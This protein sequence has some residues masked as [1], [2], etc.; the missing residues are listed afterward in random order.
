MRLPARFIAGNVIWGWDGSVW[1]VY[2]VE[3]VSYPWLP[4]HEKLRMHARTKDALLALPGEAMVVSICAALPPGDLPELA[5]L[6]VDP[7]ERRSFLVAKLSAR[8]A[9]RGGHAVFGP[10]A[11]AVLGAF[12]LAS[13]PAG[14]EEVAARTDQAEH[15]LAR[16]GRL[17]P[18]RA[19]AA[20]EVCWLY[21]SAVRRGL[22]PCPAQPT[23]ADEA[24]RD[25]V[26]GPH[27]VALADAI[28]KEGGLPSDRD[29]PAHRRYLRVEAE[30]GVVYQGLLAVSDM[31]HTFRFP[32]GGGE[33]LPAAD[34]A[35]FPV[36]WCV[37]IRPVSN[38]TAQASARR[39]AR[40]LQSQ[41]GEHAGDP[42]GAP[43]GLSEA[44]ETIH[45]LRAQLAANPAD[46]ELEVSTILA[47][48][49]QDL[50]ELEERVSALRSMYAAEGYQ[51]HRPIG[52]Q[53]GLFEAL[54]PGSPF[55]RPAGDYLHHLLGRD[56]A[57]GMPFGT[58]G[59]GD[60]EGMLLGYCAD[61]GTFRPVL[62]DPARGPGI[63]RSGSLGAFGALGS[64]KS[65]FIKNVLHAT[66]ARGGRVVAL[67]RTAAGEYVRVADVVPGRAQVV[68][69][70]GGSP[71]CLD[72]MRIF[73]PEERTDVALGFLTLITGTA[74]NELP[75]LALAEAVRVVAQRPKGRLADVLEVLEQ[76]S[77]H[78]AG[79]E[80]AWRILRSA[81]YSPLAR[82]AFG[83]GKTATLDADYLVLHAPGLS[84]PDRDATLRE[85]LA[86]RLLPEQVL[87]QAL[88]Y[89]VAAVARRMAFSDTGRFA[90]VLFDEAWSLAA[91]PQGRSLLADGIRDGRKHNAA[92]WV[93][94]QH[95]DDLGDGELV[96]LLG[97][98]FVFRQARAAAPAA[99]RFVG[100]EPSERAVDLLAA[101]PEGTCLFRDVR[102]RVGRLQVLPAMSDALH[103]AFETNPVAT[104]G[105]R[106]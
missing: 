18:A 1:A 85:H 41:V 33:W 28:F 73:A 68:R 56:L 25:H 98:R 59:V 102:D 67:D 15:L 75:T 62:F 27:L 87:S 34:T 66:V 46:A 69:L 29:R 54:L 80:V 8:P 10:A 53:L 11:G 93:L 104:R 13:P 61:A 83:D 96:D 4:H 45:E 100:V 91:S 50:L 70:A 3:A 58:V 105:R 20:A 7:M 89:L 49:S 78:V 26:P 55:R 86:R 72:P 19:A 71:V 79:A 2:A 35:A 88:L 21:R 31:P 39:Q 16:L 6:Q 92:V 60:P 43:P 36:D 64:G 101:A 63:N 38:Q 23:A 90:A 9:G 32:G 77:G 12:G 76:S 48:A 106:I 42:A 24:V 95:P 84:L 22:P 82:I 97:P 52:G 44:L 30:A 74:P 5:A 14:R 17:L 51:L 99:L 47:V 37:R 81:S 40:Q 94:S 65:Y 103:E 57:A